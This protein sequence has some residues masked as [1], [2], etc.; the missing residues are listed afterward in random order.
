[1]DYDDQ[2]DRAI[3]ETPDVQGAGS[4]FEVPEPRLRKDGNFTVVE[5]FLDVVERLGREEDHVL[6][7]LQSELGTAAQIDENGRARLTGEF[8][9]S[10]VADALSEYAE[11]FVLCPEC[12][13]PDTT[14]VTES[15]AEMLKCDACGALSPMGE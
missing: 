11:V 4:R 9:E 15:G 12:G 2:L 1:M 14:L 8:R 7:Y 5:N 3:E 13:L 6:K 10:R